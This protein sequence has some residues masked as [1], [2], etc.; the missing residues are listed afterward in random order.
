MMKRTGLAVVAVLLALAVL[1][2]AF[3][4]KDH[5]LRADNARTEALFTPARQLVVVWSEA[6]DRVDSH[7]Q[8][9]ER[10]S[11]REA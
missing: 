11:E 7:M 6:W 4:G 5:S 3:S 8:R 10:R 1:Y 9:F 2:Y